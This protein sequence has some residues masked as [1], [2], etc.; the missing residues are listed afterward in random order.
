[1]KQE[2]TSLKM[3]KKVVYRVNDEKMKVI[4]RILLTE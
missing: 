3:G 1:M 2:L 4:T